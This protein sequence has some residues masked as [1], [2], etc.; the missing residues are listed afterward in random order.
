[1]SAGAAPR[2]AAVRTHRV[3]YPLEAPMADALHYIPSRAALL[4]EVESDDGTTGIGE[5]AI[6]LAH[7]DSAGGWIRLS[8]ASTPAIE[9]AKPQ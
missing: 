3:D 8:P 1:M 7:R 4:V 9:C 6:F 2:I 5:S